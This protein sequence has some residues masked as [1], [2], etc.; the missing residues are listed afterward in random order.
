MSIIAG[1][2]TPTDARMMWKPSVNAIWLRAASSWEAA[3]GSRFASIARGTLE[4][5]RDLV[6]HGGQPCDVPVAPAQ[7]E[8]Q[9]LVLARRHMRQVHDPRHDLPGNERVVVVER[10]GRTADDA[11]KLPREAQLR[12]HPSRCALRSSG[13]AP[14]VRVRRRSTPSSS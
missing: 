4:P 14:A 1:K 10:A 2:P 7:G 12:P 11:T 8:A 13:R 3:R 6:V 9:F 5:L